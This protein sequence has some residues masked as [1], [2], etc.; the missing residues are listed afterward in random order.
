MNIFKAFFI[1]HLISALSFAASVSKE[2]LECRQDNSG[3]FRVYNKNSQIF[4]GTS[5]ST[6]LAR[7][8]EYIATL[9]NNLVCTYTTEEHFRPFHALNGHGYG[10]ETGSSELSRC[11]EYINTSS[12]NLVC[13]YEGS[14]SFKVFRISDGELLGG[15]NGSSGLGRCEEYIKTETSGAYCQYDRKE[16]G[17]NRYLAYRIKDNQVLGFPHGTYA[18]SMEACAEH[19]INLELDGNADGVLRNIDD[20]KS[21]IKQVFL[22]ELSPLVKELS[23]D[24]YF[25]S[26]YS[27]E[28]LGLSNSKALSLKDPELKSTIESWRSSFDTFIPFEKGW[29]GFGLYGAVNPVDSQAYAA[30]DW[31]L[32]ETKVPSGSRYYDMRMDYN[33]S[34]YN[35]S[36]HFTSRAKRTLEDVCKIP[37]ESFEKIKF[38][39]KGERYFHHINKVDLT[40][41]RICHEALVEA[42]QELDVDFLAYHWYYVGQKGIRSRNACG[43][44]NTAAALFTSDLNTERFSMKFLGKKGNEEFKEEYQRMYQLARLSA[45]SPKA[46]WPQYKDKDAPLIDVEAEL[47]NRFDCSESFPE[48]SPHL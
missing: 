13:K 27:K 11:E 31:V 19:L 30:G 14:K 21:E 10:K 44:E 16:D 39:L 46:S 29:L 25:Y 45:N 26:Y 1:I 4:I 32:T 8:E 40:K 15:G 34:E 47:E 23:H 35:Y 6:D 5:G 22:E 28:E 41:N 42:L 2:D 36:F 37:E 24:V 38:K 9:K 43:K 48:D 17:E 33:R 12:S 3:T 20:E 7:C 18:P